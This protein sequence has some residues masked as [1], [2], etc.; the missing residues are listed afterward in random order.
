M[1]QFEPLVVVIIVPTANSVNLVLHERI[2]RYYASFSIIFDITTS[3][4]R[5]VQYIDHMHT[6]GFLGSL[7]TGFNANQ[8]S[9]TLIPK[10]HLTNAKNAVD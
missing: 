10:F 8:Y 6:L 5:C 1:L 3:G 9:Q 2:Q 7:T 4:T